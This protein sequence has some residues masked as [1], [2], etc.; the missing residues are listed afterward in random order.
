VF[1]AI[2]RSEQ[3]S[4]RLAYR[5]AWL[6]LVAR[7]PARARPMPLEN[8]YKQECP[9]TSIQPC[10]PSWVE[11]P[12]ICPITAHQPT[13]M[14]IARV[15]RGSAAA[16]R[17]IEAVHCLVGDDDAR[18]RLAHRVLPRPP[19]PGMPAHCVPLNNSATSGEEF[20]TA[21]LTGLR[22]RFY[23]HSIDLRGVQRRMVYRPNINHE[24]RRRYRRGAW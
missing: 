16:R 18:G 5:S 3:G 6:G 9:N 13:K 10:H 8:P 12:V 17:R 15:P 7:F 1:H 11:S 21:R 4:L 22:S 2:G 14:L 19:A 24:R 23:K 20:G